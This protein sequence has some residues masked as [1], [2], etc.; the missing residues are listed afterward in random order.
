MKKVLLLMA[1]A[2][3]IICGCKKGGEDNGDT[4]PLNANFTKFR[5]RSGLS[6]TVSKA[7]T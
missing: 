7:Q 5:P 6:G 3:T 1:A 2:A 4:T